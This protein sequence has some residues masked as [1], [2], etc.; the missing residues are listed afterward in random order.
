MRVEVLGDLIIVISEGETRGELFIDIIT[1]C[2][3]TRGSY[4]DIRGGDLR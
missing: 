4:C 3:V 1:R 2:E